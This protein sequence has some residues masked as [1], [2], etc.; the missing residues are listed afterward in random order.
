MAAARALPYLPTAPRVLGR[1]I[2]PGQSPLH[3]RFGLHAAL[4]RVRGEPASGVHSRWQRGGRLCFGG[5]HSSR[6]VE[7]APV[8]SA[9]TCRVPT[10]E[11]GR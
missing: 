1:G 7:R 10:A 4:P 2:I 6:V 3:P 8:K 9:R 5:E 11:G